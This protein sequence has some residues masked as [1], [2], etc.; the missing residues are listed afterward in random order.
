MKETQ[1]IRLGIIGCGHAAD[2]LHLPALRTLDSVR[3]VAL[4]DQDESRLS[5]VAV[6]S[7]IAARYRDYRALLDDNAVDAVCVCVPTA[8]HAEVALA[9]LDAGKHVLI[10]KPLAVRIDEADAVIRRAAQ[11]PA[12]VVMVG[13]NLRFH[14]Q[15]QAARAIVA[16]GGIGRMLFA[17]SIWTSSVRMRLG[18]PDWRRRRATGGGA[19]FEIGIHIVDMWRFILGAELEEVTAASRNLQTEDESAVIAA[20]LSNG[21]LA[22]AVVSQ[23]AFDRNE[24]EIVGSSGRVRIEPYRFGAPDHLRGSGF[25]GNAASGVWAAVRQ[26]AGIPAALNAR[27]RGGSM[28]E[29][30]RREWMEFAAAVRGERPV[31]SNLEDARRALVAVH[32]FARAADH[33][34]VTAVGT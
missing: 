33:G 21:V 14:P 13:F 28:A 9:A 12:S 4:A 19:L 34:G 17:R 24:L 16:D 31:A 15:V 10:E 25:G 5:A 6:R 26:I 3:A 7:N 30:Y 2:Q 23:N 1:P 32:A 11:T 27:R 8:M 22:S 29:T 20:R 18:L